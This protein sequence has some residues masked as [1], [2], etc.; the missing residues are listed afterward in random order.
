MIELFYTGVIIG[1]LVSAPMGPIGM[2]CI[3]RTLSKGRWHGFVSGLGA[4]LSDVIY[5]AI[6]GLFMGLVVNFVEAHQQPL[7]IFGSIMLGAFGYYIFQSNPVKQLK[8]NREQK[9]SFVQDFVS[10]FLLTFSNVLIVLLYIGLFARF[11][12]VFSASVWDVPSGLGGIAAGAILW[13]FF[14]TYIVSK[15]RR[16]FNIRGIR[17]LNQIVGG[18]ILSLSVVGIVYAFIE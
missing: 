10:A 14:V 4:A 1:I 3:Q 5:A 17:I 9:M 8:K 2:L 12:F 7:R 11:A 15:L 18:V 16:W 13:W 6:T